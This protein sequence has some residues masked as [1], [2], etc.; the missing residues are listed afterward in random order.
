MI[1][2]VPIANPFVDLTPLWRYMVDATNH[3]MVAFAARI[4]E[5]RYTHAI[6]HLWFG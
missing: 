3:H 5:L 1:H 4:V 2:L 6:G